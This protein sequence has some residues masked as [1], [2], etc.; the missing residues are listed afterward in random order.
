MGLVEKAT[1]LF[2]GVFDGSKEVGLFAPLFWAILSWPRTRGQL[3]S[4]TLS[5]LCAL[6]FGLHIV[7]SGGSGSPVLRQWLT[8][9]ELLY[10]LPILVVWWFA[11]VL[12]P[13]PLSAA[14]PLRDLSFSQA[15][16]ALA[17]CSFALLGIGL[18]AVYRSTWS[19]RF[20]FMIWA[21]S[22]FRCSLRQHFT[23][24]LWGVWFCHRDP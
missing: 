20:R 14:Y 6:V 24:A 11:R 5:L 9:S 7:D 16:V 13:W 3:C 15:D 21:P 2:F 23:A 22:P 12:W 10:S 18:V 19:H 1:L 4:I 17:L 8:E